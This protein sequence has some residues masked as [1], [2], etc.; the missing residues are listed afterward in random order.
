M[1]ARLFAIPGSH[2]SI[3]ATLILEHKGISFRRIDLPPGISKSLLR[4]LGFPGTTV[5]AIKL[6]GRHIQG[7]RQIASTLDQLRPDPP[8]FPTSPEQR[9]LV[10]EAERFGDEDLQEPIRQILWTALK[11]DSRPLRSYLEGAKLGVPISLAARTGRTLVALS[12]RRERDEEGPCRF[13]TEL[14]ALLDRVDAWIGEG[15]LDGAQLNAAD[16]QIAPSLRLA[17]TLDDLR[18]A[19]ESRPSGELAKRVVPRYPGHIPPILPAAWLE[20]LR[21]LAGHGSRVHSPAP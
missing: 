8:L 13:L 3:T 12:S 2:P 21:P 11:R 4:R 18:P 16:F 10:E 15:I 17:M 9:T 6:D 14:P 19:I 7:S 20:P 1:E 5:P